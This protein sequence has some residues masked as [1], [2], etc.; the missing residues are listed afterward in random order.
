[1][2]RLRFATLA[3]AASLSLVGGCC[4]LAR[5]HDWREARQARLGH[6]GCCCEGSVST[7][8]GPMLPEFGPGPGPAG[9]G[10][11]S[12]NG[13]PELMTPPRLVPKSQATPSPA[14]PSQR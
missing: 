9:G 1:M 3:V 14:S 8:N 4:P 13:M 2:L 10:A 6:N 12:P 11:T 5:I 7:F